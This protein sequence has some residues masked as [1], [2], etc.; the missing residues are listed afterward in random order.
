MKKS[1]LKAE[2]Q[3]NIAT[4]K[5]QLAKY[6]RMVRGGEEIIILDHKMP[7]AKIVPLDADTSDPL[8]MIKPLGKFS[9]VARMRI[10]PVE[11]KGKWNSLI[12]L[13]EE[14]GSR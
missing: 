3:V 5:A 12:L 10:P 9:D 7:I 8:E 4:L 14:R 6:L 11:K 2:N 13:L 1:S